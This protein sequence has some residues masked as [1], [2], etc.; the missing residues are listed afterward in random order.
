MKKNL[1]ILIFAMLILLVV[2]SGIIILAGNC[3]KQLP[4]AL[5][6]K[7]Y[8][9]YIHG[10]YVGNIYD[11]HDFYTTEQ[12]NNPLL[13]SGQNLI[14]CKD[15]ALQE[16]LFEFA[17]PGAP[18]NWLYR[19]SIADKS[20]FSFIYKDN[21]NEERF[22]VVKITFKTSRPK[23]NN[24]SVQDI[25]M[26][27]I[28]DVPSKINRIFDV[29]E[30]PYTYYHTFVCQSKDRKGIFYYNEKGDMI[31]RFDIG[32]EYTYLKC[33]HT[34]DVNYLYTGDT[35]F[36]FENGD[37]RLVKKNTIILDTK[38][39]ID[40]ALF[41]NDRG[42][43]EYRG[44]F[45]P[46]LYDGAMMYAFYEGKLEYSQKL[47]KVEK[48]SGYE[49]FP[50]KDG[51]FAFRRYLRMIEYQDNIVNTF[52]NGRIDDSKH[53]ALANRGSAKYDDYNI[54]NRLEDNKWKPTIYSFVVG[55]IDP[56]S[57]DFT[58]HRYYYYRTTVEGI[59][60]K[61]IFVLYNYYKKT[62]YFFSKNYVYSFDMNDA[63]DT[64]R[65]IIQVTNNI[66]QN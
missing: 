55:G 66:E 12:A 51:L 54:L 60:E 33:Y 32:K 49:L 41:E 50:Y 36:Y 28:F 18:K 26:K 39:N 21:K 34:Q 27:I 24:Y 52:I 65:D 7:T 10:I 4:A 46:V 25:K 6:N 5:A 9:Q 44:I 30:N 29:L 3:E 38:G 23:N 64:K 2:I 31:D 20:F 22:A 11:V 14:V 56:N 15:Y 45:I 63:K 35:V 8:Y 58:K 42:F 16:K 1:I 48:S 37:N 59:D 17:L 43:S 47:E 19:G 61:I 57:Y 40:K 13:L 62:W 53:E